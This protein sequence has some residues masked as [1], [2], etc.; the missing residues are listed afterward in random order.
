MSC[1]TWAISVTVS[2]NLLLIPPRDHFR[3][4]TPLPRTSS[5]SAADSG[6]LSGVGGE[7]LQSRI[8]ERW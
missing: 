8:S 2:S 6:R 1:W 7:E 5:R 4:V 3:A